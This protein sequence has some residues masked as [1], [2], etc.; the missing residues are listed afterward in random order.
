MI[1]FELEDFAG[2][3][4]RLSEFRGR[5]VVLVVAG[6]VSGEAAGR[7]AAALAPR[8]AESEAMVVS[9]A[10]T[11]SV[12]RLVRGVA[13]SAI[14]SGIERVQREA[15]R[16]WPDLPPDAWERFLFL[17]DWDGAALDRLAL[18][19][20]THRFHVLVLDRQG[21][22]QGRLVQG[23][24]PQPEQIETVAGWLKAAS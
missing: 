8:L 19:G 22:E 16:E 17:L 11:S 5:P 2:T 10:D 1:D 15:A 3:R 18:R 21:Q 13:R 14:R 6:R 23:D 7:F 4:R 9:V 12:P 24:A 20:Q